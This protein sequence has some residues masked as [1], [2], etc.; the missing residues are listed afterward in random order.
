M[1]HITQYRGI[2]WESYCSWL[3]IITTNWCHPI[4]AKTDALIRKKEGYSHSHMFDNKIFMFYYSTLY[5][6]IQY[7]TTERPGVAMCVHNSATVGELVAVSM[8]IIHSCGMPA[9]TVSLI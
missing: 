4:S 5:T 9:A 8:L 6:I 7:R 2:P 1:I 3:A